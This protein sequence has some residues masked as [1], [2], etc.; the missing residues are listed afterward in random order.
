MRR[1]STT[2]LV[3]ALLASLPAGAK[4]KKDKGPPAD[5]FTATYVNMGGPGV[6]GDPASAFIRIEAYTSNDEA[7]ALRNVLREQGQ[8]AL[9]DLLYKNKNGFLRVGGSL[10]QNLGAVR[11]FETDKETVI[12]AILPRPVTGFEIREGLRSQDYPFGFI[13]LRL[14]KEGNGEGQLI[15]A[16]QITIDPG[17][18]VEVESLGTQP[19][20]LMN[21]KKR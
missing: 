5:E 12:L 21:V 8:K 11:R 20:R 15:A 1:L 2:I 18:K 9:S 19:I 3:L 10:G 4:E 17:G 16:A 6:V 13:E 14:D 7:L